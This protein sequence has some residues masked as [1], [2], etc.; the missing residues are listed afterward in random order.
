M[1]HSVILIPGLGNNEKLL[2]LATKFWVKY[3]LNQVV[4]P[5]EWNNNDVTFSNKLE[6]LLKLIDTLIEQDNKISI[7]GIS[8]GG[9]AAIN[10]VC[11]RKDKINK[12]VSV[13]G[14]LK[15]G[16]LTGFRSFKAK[17][18]TSAAFAQS[19]ILCEENIKHLTEND[20]K[21]IMTIRAG[22]GDELVPANTTFVE[23]AYNTVIPTG[24][25]VFSIAMALTMFSKELI[26]FI[27]N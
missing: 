8:A 25:H 13:C 12:V 5:I 10:A 6:K 24:E 15:V 18:A 26:E 20:K 21:K 2:E 4:Y 16:N 17:T 14:R 22:F 19:V 11:E 1:K 9:S 7:V 23:G 3:G 27:V